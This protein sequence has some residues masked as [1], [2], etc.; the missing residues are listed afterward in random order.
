MKLKFI[1]LG[2]KNSESF[3]PFIN[4]YL[5]RLNAYTKWEVFFFSEKNE[6]KLDKRI[7]GHI[8]QGD[9]FIVLDEKGKCMNTLN[10]AKFIRKKMENHASVIFLVGG[11]FGVPKPIINK[12]DALLSFSEMT[13]PH[14]IARL[15]LVEQTYRAFSILNNHPYHHE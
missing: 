12:C 5:K 6:I 14:L 10:Y 3:N 7:S 11:S 1:F 4:D 2:K 8:K 15:M 13:F 9:Y